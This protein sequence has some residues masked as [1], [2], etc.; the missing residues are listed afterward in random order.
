M[1][2]ELPAVDGS[3]TDSNAGDSASRPATNKHSVKHEPTTDLGAA[4][5]ELLRIAPR[6]SRSLRASRSFAQSNAMDTEETVSSRAM[7]T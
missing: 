4:F 6:T 5:A 3:A 1:P 2:S 7:P